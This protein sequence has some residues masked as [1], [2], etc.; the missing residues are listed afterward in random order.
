MSL[1]ELLLLLA[2]AL[3]QLV[4]GGVGV[5]AA[6]PVAAPAES[7]GGAA[8]RGRDTAGRGRDAARRGGDAV[9]QR[10]AGDGDGSRRDR[11]RPRPGRGRLRVCRRGGC[12]LGVRAG[13][14]LQA[15]GQGRG[16]ARVR[17]GVRRGAAGHP[18]RKGCAGRGRAGSDAFAR[19]GRTASEAAAPDVTAPRWCAGRRHGVG[20]QQCAALRRPRAV[21]PPARVRHLAHGLRRW[22]AALRASR[23]EARGAVAAGTAGAWIGGGTTAGAVDERRRVAS[24]RRRRPATGGE[25]TP[26]SPAGDGAAAARCI[27]CGADPAGSAPVRGAAVAR[28]TRRAPAGDGADAGDGRRATGCGRA[29]DG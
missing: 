23:I 16:G 3:E 10:R 21:R 22:L 26:G 7:G 4:V 5:A 18:P 9:R 20:F 28:C 27:R 6:A 19:R 2:Q 15:P 25:A 8:G 17:I 24:A 12:G 29:F 1:A 14:A 11:G 13:R